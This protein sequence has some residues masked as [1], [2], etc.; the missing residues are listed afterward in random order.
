MSEDAT[1]AGA[2]A[3][4]RA[5][6]PAH[7]EPKSLPVKPKAPEENAPVKVEREEPSS[8]TPAPWTDEDVDAIPVT[9]P[10]GTRVR[11][12]RVK[13][14]FCN[15]TLVARWTTESSSGMCNACAGGQAHRWLWMC[16]KHR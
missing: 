3:A 13:C 16:A 8:E 10:P 15:R 11:S 1:K 12:T 2:R 9:S 4:A 7:V 6:L 5:R 14:R